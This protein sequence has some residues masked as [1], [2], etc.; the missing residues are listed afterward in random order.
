MSWSFEFS[1]KSI[2]VKYK[3]KR[4]VQLMTDRGDYED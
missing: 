4:S 1:N 3:M 2:G